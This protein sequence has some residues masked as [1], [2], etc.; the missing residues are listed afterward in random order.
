MEDLALREKRG[1]FAEDQHNRLFEEE[2]KSDIDSMTNL[3]RVS[4]ITHLQKVNDRYSPALFILHKSQCSNL[5]S[6]IIARIFSFSATEEL[7]SLILSFSFDS[8]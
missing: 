3:I 7:K 8:F 1:D 6:A 2:V 4:I 5:R